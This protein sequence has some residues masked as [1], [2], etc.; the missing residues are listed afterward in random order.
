MVGPNFHSPPPA[1]VKQ[2]T[3][4]PLP[5]KTVHTKGTGGKAQRFHPDTDLPILWWELFHS[6]EINELI[7]AGL[8]HS[9]NV[10][11]AAAALRQAGENWKAQIGSS[12]LPQVNG[13][14]GVIRQRYS[15]VQIGIPGD[16]QTF[17]LY[18]PAFNLS[19]TLD[20]F[21]GARRQIEGLHAQI[22]YQRFQLIAAKVTL[23]TNIVTTAVNIASYQAQIDAT[24][25]LIK[26]QSNIL[27]VL[28]AQYR[29]GGISNADVLTQ[30]ALVEQSKATL[31]PLE[32]NLARAKH[33]MSAL[34][35]TFPDRPLPIIRLDRLQLPGDLP[36]TIPSM[37]VRQRPDIRSAE[38]TM[39]K[40]MT[41]IGVATANL[42][43]QL[44]LSASDGWLNTTWARL[45]TSTNNVWS[46]AAQASQPL[47]RGGSLLA[48]RR[49]AIAGFDQAAA[50]YQQTVLQAFQNVADVL[51]AIEADARTLQAKILAEDAA[52]ASLKLTMDQYRLG[53]ANYVNLLYAQRQYQQ[54]RINRIQAQ[55]LRYTDTAA[56]FQALGGGWWR[57][58]WCAQTCL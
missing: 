46:I 28:A 42:L 45:F 9:P 8:N 36:V 32:T 10:T 31:P 52:R 37:L 48:Q 27:D 7:T 14:M 16:S 44:T 33:S 6:P 40:A 25:D 29:S 21:G 3:E 53:A 58:P 56:L 55:A 30:K 5:L 39:H 20:L 35:G 18:N 50:Q 47:F 1:P 17:S 24:N 19:Y 54:A 12:L 4:K 2:F 23:T 43:P 34:I 41:Q 57:K 51:T 38:A 22:D 11:A 13:A 15:G 49:A 26:A